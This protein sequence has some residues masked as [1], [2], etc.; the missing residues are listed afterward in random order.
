MHHLENE[1]N[2]KYEIILA[3]TPDTNNKQHNK[4]YI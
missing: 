3:M 2:E 1:K 4:E